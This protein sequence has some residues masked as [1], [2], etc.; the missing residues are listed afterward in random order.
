MKINI[1]CVGKI[2][3]KYLEEA[4][5]EYKKRL[6]KY[7]DLSI[8]ELKDEPIKDSNDPKTIEGERILHYLN[9]GYTILLAIEGKDMDSVSFAQKI[10]S[11]FTY[12]ASEINFVIGGSLGVSSAIYEKADMLLSFSRFT[13]PHPLMRVILLEQIYRA[14][15]INNH[16][17]YHK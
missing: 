4:I 15:K 8:I 11:I 17:T 2:K 1:Y 12:E 9:K 7:V 14:F 10:D 5:S 6:S 13:F 16:E 3:E